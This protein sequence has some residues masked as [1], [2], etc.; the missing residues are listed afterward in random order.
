MADESENPLGSIVCGL[1]SDLYLIFDNRIEGKAS[2]AFLHQAHF[3]LFLRNR[4]E[5]KT[6]RHYRW[7]RSIQ[8]ANSPAAGY[9]W[10]NLAVATDS[11]LVVAHLAQKSAC[12]IRAVSAPREQNA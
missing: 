6:S 12:G 3:S 1:G 4:D 10:L 11:A 9:S 5:R 8:R 2:A 7:Q